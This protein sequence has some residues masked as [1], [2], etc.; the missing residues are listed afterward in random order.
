MRALCFALLL[1]VASSPMMVRAEEPG[2]HAHLGAPTSAAASDPS[3]LRSDLA[4]WTA[5]VFLLLLVILRKFAWG[6]ISKALDAREQRVADDLAAAAQHHQEAKNLLAQY[7]QK[8][9]AAQDEVRAILD[10]ARRNAAKSQEE[11]MA[12]ARADA[13]AE[14]D[15][16]KREIGLARD[17]ALQ[18]LAETAANLAVDLAGKILRTKLQASDHANLVREAVKEFVPAA[19]PN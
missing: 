13:A 7:E 5:V 15:R 18:Q 10:E 6:P 17:Q 14:M 12:K 11:L 16:A 3:E 4:V 8:L 1:A 9:A 19:S 2:G